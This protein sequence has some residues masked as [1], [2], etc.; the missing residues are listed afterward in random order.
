MKENANNIISCDQ[1][2]C[3]QLWSIRTLKIIHSYLF[4]P[5]QV[6]QMYLLILVDLISNCVVVLL[7]MQNFKEPKVGGGRGAWNSSI[8]TQYK[9]LFYEEWQKG[10]TPSTSGP[11]MSSSALLVRDGEGKRI[12]GGANR[13]RTYLPERGGGICGRRRWK[14]AELLWKKADN[15]KIMRNLCSHFQ[16]RKILS[17]ESRCWGSRASLTLR[18]PAPLFRFFSRRAAFVRCRWPNP[19]PSRNVFLSWWLS[20]P[21]SCTP[22][23]QCQKRLRELVTWLLR[24]D[25]PPGITSLNPFWQLPGGEKFSGGINIT[26]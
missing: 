9:K 2:P 24:V 12:G 16:K 19:S 7:I 21:R 22:P 23:V 17:L 13:V 5:I 25:K 6:Y 26:A 1:P 20:S 15:A 14:N 18:T 10:R 11:L 3:N 4:T 8:K